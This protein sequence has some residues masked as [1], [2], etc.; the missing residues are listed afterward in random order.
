METE[1]G[2][3][4]F[5]DSRKLLGSMLVA[6][7]FS[8]A[9]IGCGQ[10]DAPYR[11]VSDSDAARQVAVTRPTLSD[12]AQAGEDIF[13]ASC[14]LCHGAN[15]AGT[16]Q[17]PTL[18]DAI[19]KPGHHSDFS[20]RAAIRQGV[21]QHHWSFGDM[22]PVP[23]VPPDDVEKIICYVREMQQANGIFEGDAGLSA[24]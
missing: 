16:R 8:L 24:C 22:P 14:S 21:R 7:L 20:I 4:G 17:G 10:R 13:I 23:G 12:R 5:R 19:Y 1:S 6:T 2:M 11:Q 9:I 18:I 15:A 3:N